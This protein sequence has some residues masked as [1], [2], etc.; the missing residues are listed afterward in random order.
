MPATEQTWRDTKK[1]HVIFG[2]ASVVMLLTT[3][4]MLAAD[5]AREWKHY[6]RT[7]RDVETASISNRIAQQ[8]NRQ[9]ERELADLRVL[10]WKPL[11][12]SRRIPR[13]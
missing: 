9:Y 2:I 4:W 12:S 8:E 6:Q 3:V 5:H 1:M 11:S 7:F 10:P 13:W